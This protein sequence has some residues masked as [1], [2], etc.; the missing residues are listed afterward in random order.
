M[1]PVP[2]NWSF[3]DGAAF[4]SGRFHSGELIS[5][6]P[7]TTITNYNYNGF[8]QNNW[9]LHFHLGIADIGGG[10]QDQEIYTTSSFFSNSVDFEI[11]DM[12]GNIL[13]TASP[14]IPGLTFQLRVT[15]H[16]TQTRS[17]SG[18]FSGTVK[19]LA[20]NTKTITN[21]VFNGTYP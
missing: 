19:D 10:I 16:N 17:I 9:L 13:Y 6:I 20:G 2:V 1:T 14:T 21:G 12:E 8:Y 4:Y 5:N 18:T 11:Q 15:N 3:N 7:L